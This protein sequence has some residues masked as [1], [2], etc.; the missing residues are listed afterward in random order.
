M[1]KGKKMDSFNQEE[2]GRQ[3]S[4]PQISKKKENKKL[5]LFTR[6]RVRNDGPIL[7]QRTLIL[8]HEENSLTE[9]L[10]KY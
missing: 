3:P 5:P 1:R 8:D 4:I 6:N 2:T 7:Q 9:R 10:I